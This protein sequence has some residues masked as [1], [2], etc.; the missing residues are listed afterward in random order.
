MG[1]LMY[2][3][4]DRENGDAA[5]AA[6]KD[7]EQEIARMHA[8]PYA[9]A[10]RAYDAALA[11]QGKAAAEAAWNREIRG[12]LEGSV[13]P[14]GLAF[15]EFVAH[16]GV[17]RYLRMTSSCL[18]CAFAYGMKRED[19][20]RELHRWTGG[21]NV[22][23]TVQNLDSPEHFESGKDGESAARTYW[24][25]IWALL[26]SMVGAVVHLFK[27]AFTVTEYAHRRGPGRGRG[28]FT[29]AHRVVGR[30]RRLHRPGDRGALPLH[31]LLRQPRDG[32]GDVRAQAHRAMW[33]AQPVI[34]AVAGHWTINAQGLV[35]PFTRKFRPSWLDFDSD[36]LAWMPGAGAQVNAPAKPA[37]RH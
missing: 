29:L 26:F 5:Y 28:G 4:W 11:S 20:T 35:Y 12:L 36:P 17:L 16:P 27:M 7:V 32:H 24:V 8:G 30:S 33:S 22:K 19:Y 37:P 23:T 3:D 9:D 18:D 6:Y 25:P 2:H 34:G 10:S 15:A 31:L 1:E 14:P 13:V 21:E